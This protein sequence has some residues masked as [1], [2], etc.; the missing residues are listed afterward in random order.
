MLCCSLVDIQLF[1]SPWQCLA[2]HSS[3]FCSINS[4]IMGSSFFHFLS[5]ILSTRASCWSRYPRYSEASLCAAFCLSVKSI[6]ASIIA[7][8]K[9]RQNRAWPVDKIYQMACLGLSFSSKMTKWVIKT[10]NL[11]SF[12]LFVLPEIVWVNICTPA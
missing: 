8:A 12:S 9:L 11:L 2:R 5:M 10:M 7:M 3:I 4:S 6:S 1:L